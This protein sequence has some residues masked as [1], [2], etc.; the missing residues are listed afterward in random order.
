MFRLWGKTFLHNRMTNDLVV[1][2]DSEESRTTKIFQAV[3]EICQTFDPVSY[4][5]LRAHET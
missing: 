1:C 4:T 3:T 2:N 5:H